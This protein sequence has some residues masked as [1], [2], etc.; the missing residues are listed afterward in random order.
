MSFELVLILIAIMGLTHLIVDSTIFNR[1][2][3]SPLQNYLFIK[4]KIHPD[5]EEEHF[6]LDD[7]DE[8]ILK[9]DTWRRRRLAEVDEMM[10][11]YQCSGFWSGLSVVLICLLATIPYMDWVKVS[12]Y[13]FA[14]SYLGMLGASVLSYLNGG[15]SE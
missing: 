3:K 15:K 11:C 4:E 9:K 12:L 5:S 7:R 8:K 10:G 2:V 6:V 1:Y 14:G 13:A